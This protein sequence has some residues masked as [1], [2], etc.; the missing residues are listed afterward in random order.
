[1]LSVSPD[2][3][4]P[5]LTPSAPGEF[6]FTFPVPATA[7]LGYAPIY[8]QWLALDAGIP[9]FFALTQAGKTVL[10]P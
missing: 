5:L 7:A 1:V 4:S 8:F 9:G 10:Y 3:S 6:R 2:L